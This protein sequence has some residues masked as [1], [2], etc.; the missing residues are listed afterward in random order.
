MRSANHSSL[1]GNANREFDIAG[2]ELR[3]GRLAEAVNVLSRASKADPSNVDLL[4]RLGIAYRA[5]DRLDAAR[6][7]LERAVRLAAGRHAVARLTLANVLELDQRPDLALM[8]YLLGLHEAR[9]AGRSSGDSEPDLASL[10]D[11]AARYVATG[12]RAWFERAL[13]NTVHG[14]VHCSRRIQQAL[15]MYLEGRAPNIADRRQR[16]GPLHV[17]DIKTGCFLDRACFPWLDRAAALIAP[18]AGEMDACIAAAGAAQV[19]VYQ[20]GVLQYHARQHAPR[21]LRALAELPLAQISHEAPDVEIFALGAKARMPLQYGRANSRCRVIINC[22]DG[23]AL[24]VTVGG[25]TRALEA[26]Q[27]RVVDASFGIE[28]ANPGANRGRALLAEV[29]HPELSGE[30]QGSLSALILAAIDFDMR[31]QELNS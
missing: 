20:R 13:Q 10:L 18:C 9:A 21:L 17:P 31:L 26:G 15:A 30:E 11:R 1:S 7:V 23:G 4:V 12:R 27:S 6:Y 8:Q 24:Q 19:S 28:Y 22:A 25:E 16:P 5:A 2:Q 14:A 3:E 29:W